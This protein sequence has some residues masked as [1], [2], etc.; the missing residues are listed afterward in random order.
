M[1][2]IRASKN[3]NGD[4]VISK[5][6]IALFSVVFLLISGIVS[7]SVF[8]KGMESRIDFCEQRIEKIENSM[9]SLQLSLQNQEISLVEIRIL[10][11]GIRDDIQE[12]KEELKT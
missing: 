2:M 8:G 11:N 5:G 10:L 9:T 4:F 6:A 1:K 12:I 7:V 3:G